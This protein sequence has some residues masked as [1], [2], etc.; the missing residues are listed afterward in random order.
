MP[1]M[2]LLP[3]SIM[4]VGLVDRQTKTAPSRFGSGH[5]NVRGM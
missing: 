1:F 4:D 5:P 3:W 2:V